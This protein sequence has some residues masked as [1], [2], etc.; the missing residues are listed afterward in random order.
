MK[1]VLTGAPAL[2]IAR[3]H[4]SAPKAHPADKA[5]RQAAEEIDGGRYVE[6]PHGE[7]VMDNLGLALG[8]GTGKVAT[9]GVMSMEEF[10]READTTQVLNQLG[11]H[12]RVVEALERMQTETDEGKS[13]DE[14]I[15]REFMIR[16][17]L[18]ASE[19]KNK[20]EGQERWQGAENVEMRQGQVLSPWEFYDKLCKVIGHERVML[21]ERA[22]KMNKT[23][24]SGLFALV[25]KNPRWRGDQ[26][27]TKEYIADKAHKIQMDAEKELVRGQK[28]RKAKA[29][30]EA[31]K[32]MANV[33]TMVQAATEMLLGLKAAEAHEEPEF[34]RVGSLQ[35]PLGTEFM[36]LNFDEFGVPTT[37]R[38]QGWRTALLTMVRTSTITEE[39][40]MRAF[41]VSSGPAAEWFLE[42]LWMRRNLGTVVN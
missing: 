37:V 27:V 40:A 39:E 22:V 4:Q 17:M 13:P 5:I 12:P 3:R 18:Q 38:Y 42:Q 35:A 24:K 30:A 32:V 15:E 36:I 9:G 34:L 29:N 8:L 16:E 28:L 6:D 2:H 20:W 21:S 25:V 14:I 10:Q 1:K 26:T 11:R 19:E 41:P 33:G 7:A 23:A 31:D